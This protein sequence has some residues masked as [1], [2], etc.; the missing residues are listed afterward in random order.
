MGRWGDDIMLAED[1]TNDENE[2]LLC[3]CSTDFISAYL[4]YMYF[5]TYIISPNPPNNPM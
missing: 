4:I 5:P 3:M 2:D 1:N